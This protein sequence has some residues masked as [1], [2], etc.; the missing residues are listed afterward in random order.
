MNDQDQEQELE[1]IVA[2]EEIPFLPSDSDDDES[3]VAPSTVVPRWK[4]IALATYFTLAVCLGALQFGMVV[5]VASP[6]LDDFQTHLPLNFT[7]WSGFNQC[8][9]QDLVGPIAPAGAFFGSIL[10]SPV[11][12]VTG[13]VTGLVVMSSLF[14]S[15]WLLIAVSYFTYHGG[16]WSAVCFRTMLF[17][18]RLLTGVGIGWATGVVPVSAFPFIS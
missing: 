8:V 14:A 12:A 18:G 7:V 2:G 6:L 1:Q 16:E 11:V 4:T 5:V 3:V 9:Y 13:F 10:S 17:L 15:G